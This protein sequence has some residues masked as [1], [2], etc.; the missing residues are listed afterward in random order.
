MSPRDLV[1]QAELRLGS[2]VTA[3]GVLHCQPGGRCFIAGDRIDI[4]QPD[5]EASLLLVAP[6]LHFLAQGGKTR[7]GIGYYNDGVTITGHLQRSPFAPW[8]F[9]MTGLTSVHVERGDP[10]GTNHFAYDVDLT[11]LGRVNDEERAEWYRTFEEDRLPRELADKFIAQ[12]DADR[13]LW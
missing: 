2:L 11:R 7:G 5:P 10:A 9:A 3:V 13:R 6:G 4:L 12:L 8:K 1:S